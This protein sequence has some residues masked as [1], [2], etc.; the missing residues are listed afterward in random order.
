MK[1]VKLISF[2]QCPAKHASEL[3]PGDITVWNWGITEDI[4]SKDKETKNQIVFSIKTEEG[5][6]LHRRLNK[7]RLVGIKL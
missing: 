5:K 3:K 6:I 1:E 7:D 2:G 4:V